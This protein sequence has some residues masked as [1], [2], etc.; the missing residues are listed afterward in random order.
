M[1][2]L[3]SA[4]ST[5]YPAVMAYLIT[6]ILLFIYDTRLNE[7][8]DCTEGVFNNFND[9]TVIMVSVMVGIALAQILQP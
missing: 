1:I 7:H 8:H 6:V 9:T 4:V 3:R 2:G 5:S